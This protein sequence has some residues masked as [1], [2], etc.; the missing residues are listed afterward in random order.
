M[1]A[2]SSSR[3]VF[4]R[5]PLESSDVRETHIEGH[6]QCS[7]PATLTEGSWRGWLRRRLYLLRGRN[8][9]ENGTQGP[10]PPPRTAWARPKCHPGCGLRPVVA[11]RRVRLFG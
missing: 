4:G 8:V 2:Q 3:T 9:K 1:R 10:F 5:G 11:R 6:A 7:I